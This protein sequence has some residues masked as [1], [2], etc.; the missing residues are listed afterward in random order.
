MRK[1]KCSISLILAVLT[2]L[3]LCACRLSLPEP[4]EIS[5][6]DEAAAMGFSA[7]TYESEMA[8]GDYSFFKV[9]I[10]IDYEYAVKWSSSNESIATV[11]SNGRVDALAPGKVVI[12]AKAKKASVDYEVTVSKA[13][14]AALSNTT[15]ICSNDSTL[16]QNK[17]SADENNLY[18][19]L[20]NKDSC[21]I[22]AYTYNN[23]G[24]YNVP[25]RAMVCSV[26]KDVREESF[27][28]ES[29][30]EWLYTDK[31]TYHYA[32]KF[33]EYYFTSAPYSEA[34][35][36]KLVTEEY[37]KLG[38]MCAGNC[39]RLS[40]SDAKWIYENCNDTTLVKVTTNV[41]SPLGVPEP[42]LLSD[43]SKSKTWDPTDPDSKN[44]YRKATPYFEGVEDK[45]VIIGSTF[46]ARQ[47]VIAYDSCGNEYEGKVR[48]DGI[49]NCSAEGTY[50]ITYTFTDGLNRTGRADRTVKVI[51]EENSTAQSKTSE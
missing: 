28:T 38:E 1:L 22:T 50:I 17:T 34:D 4:S 40:A 24:T 47:D 27:R 41:K 37:N 20:V 9:N 42:L 5:T 15:A 26:D 25:V 19:L 43:N 11:D 10:K 36:S 31:Y 18:A 46:D 44:P 8:V 16:E 32:T 12:T 30:E 48:I 45:T 21:C 14:K 35:S 29:R 3:S 7:G 23:N 39:I 49:V 13:K 6:A 33:D 51:Y 2:V